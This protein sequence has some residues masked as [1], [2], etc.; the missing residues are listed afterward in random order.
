MDSFFDA[1]GGPFV[2]A[3][4]WCPRTTGMTM[5]IQQDIDALRAKISKAESDRDTWRA[6]GREEKYLEAFLMVEAMQL[7]LDECSRQQG[8]EGSTA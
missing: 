4:E 5:T 8:V 6:A 2:T 1:P 7:Q 3:L